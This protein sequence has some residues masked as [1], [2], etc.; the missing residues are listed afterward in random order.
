MLQS[1]TK[2]SIKISIFSIMML[3][4]LIALTTELTQYEEIAKLV[5]VPSIIMLIGL[6]I[7]SMFKSS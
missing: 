5:V 2:Q 1:L 3:I 4:G 7:Y 6:C